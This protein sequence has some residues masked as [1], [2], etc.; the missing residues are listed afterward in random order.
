MNLSSLSTTKGSEKEKEQLQHENLEKGQ[1]SVSES[2]FTGRQSGK[3][4]GSLFVASQHYFRKCRYWLNYQC[5]LLLQGAAAGYKSIPKVTL[6]K[7]WKKKSGFLALGSI[8][9][10]FILGV[11]RVLYQI[12]IEGGSHYRGHRNYESW[13]EKQAFWTLGNSWTVSNLSS[14]LDCCWFV[15]NTFTQSLSLLA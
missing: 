3:N 15:L 12:E 11:P 7:A 8:V 13:C 14:L 2:A 5:S 4:K 9:L 6:L 10:C 1:R